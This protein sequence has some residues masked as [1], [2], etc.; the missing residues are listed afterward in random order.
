MVT[1][2]TSTIDRDLRGTAASVSGT[3][4]RIGKRTPTFRIWF[5]HSAASLRSPSAIV[6]DNGDHRRTQW[7]K[8]EDNAEVH[9]EVRDKQLKLLFL[10]DHIVTLLKQCTSNKDR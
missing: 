2:R 6:S 10:I 4:K 3:G 7:Q 5:A 9:H 8:H 1:A